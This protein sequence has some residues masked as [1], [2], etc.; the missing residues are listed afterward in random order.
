M[1]DVRRLRADPEGVR[2]ALARR[3]PDVAEDV[4]R[5]LDLDVRVRQA[6][7]QRDATR[8]EVKRLTKQVG[9]ARRT[10]ERE[11]AEELQAESRR[12]GEVEKTAE[13][14]AAG[15]GAELRDVLLRTP[16]TPDPRVP[17][18]AGPDDNRVREVW[19][20]GGGR[21]EESAFADHQRLP[22]WDVA[23]HQGWLDGERAVKLSGSMFTMYTGQG[24]RLL[25]ALTQLAL[26][27]HTAAGW[28][29]V[30]PPTLVLTETMVS[31]GHLPKFADDAY[32]LERDD[33]WAIPT[34][35]VP[36]TSMARDELLEEAD[37]PRKY[38]AYTPCYRREAGSA[39]RDTRGLLRSHEFD[40]VEMMAVTRADQAEAVHAEILTAARG[41]LEDLGLAYRVVDICTGDIGFPHA[42]QVD[43]DAYSPGVGQWL[44]VSSVSWYTDFQA[45]RANIRHRVAGGGIAVCHT[46]NGSALAWPRV[47]AALVETHRQPDGTVA[48][49]E[50]LR[51]YLGGAERLGQPL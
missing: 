10:G 14:L 16:N 30:R 46:C 40:K 49:P 41:L 18:G 45:R 34:A 26:D 33:L 2:A 51:P 39:G 42:L 17:E 11:R 12:L 37:L 32:H 1:L 35:E 9:E 44:E 22:H 25:R 50:V 28:T 5:L 21:F 3:G 36:L 47:W 20:P 43:L 8:A 31:T 13:A 6:V 24:A 7:A 15:L 29:E 48:V 38:V 23:A 19:V 4:D 27:R